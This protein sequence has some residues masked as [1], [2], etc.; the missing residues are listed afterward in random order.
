MQFTLEIDDV[1]GSLLAALSDEASVEEV[2]NS[3]ISH[4]I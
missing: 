4:A 2:I 1:T 3:L